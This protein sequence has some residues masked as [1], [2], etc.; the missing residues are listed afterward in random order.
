MTRETPISIEQA[1]CNRCRYLVEFD[2]IQQCA[3][4][5]R[6]GLCPCCLDNHDC[7]SIT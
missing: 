2:G 5:E 1:I 7:E 3:G 4:C 6:D